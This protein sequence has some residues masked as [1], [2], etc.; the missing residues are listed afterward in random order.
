MPLTINV[1]LSRKASEN[2]Q[3]TGVSINVSAEL[4]QAL[5][6]RPDQL[7]Q[8]VDNLYRQAEAALDRQTARPSGQAA[9]NGNGNGAP[10]AARPADS[11]R[12]TATRGN[13]ASNGQQTTPMTQSQARA[14]QAIARRMGLDAAEECK[15]VFGW[16]LAKLTIR[17]ASEFIDHLKAVQ[18]VG[19][20]GR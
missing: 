13:G 2:F 9:A 20:G 11:A 6:A 18:P 19:N 14:I 1:G 5:L 7:Q 10:A 16:D 15:G 12:K 4:D 3:S 17:E 8:Q